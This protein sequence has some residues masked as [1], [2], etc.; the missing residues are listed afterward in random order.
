MEGKND[1]RS[2]VYILKYIFISTRSKTTITIGRQ[3]CISEIIVLSSGRGRM[4]TSLVRRKKRI[5]RHRPFRSIGMYRDAIS[6]RRLWREFSRFFFLPFFFFHFA[7]R[8][9]I[10]KATK[11]FFSRSFSEKSRTKKIISPLRSDFTAV[12]FVS[13]FDRRAILV[14]TVFPNSRE[15]RS[16]ILHTSPHSKIDQKIALI[17]ITKET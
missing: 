4:Q 5:N 16:A 11:F 10:A 15:S 13:R 6:V 14:P 9:S 8:I 3:I 7:S 2:S 17:L 12:F 1:A